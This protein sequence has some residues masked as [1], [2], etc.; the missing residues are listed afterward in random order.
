MQAFR[1]WDCHTAHADVL[2]KS[3]GAVASE[4]LHI[5]ERLS[6][7]DVAVENYLSAVL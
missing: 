2:P 1:F 3:G 4:I 6:V 5:K 7:P